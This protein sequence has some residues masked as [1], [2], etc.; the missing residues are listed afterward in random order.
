MFSLFLCMTL[1]ACAGGQTV[2]YVASTPPHPCIRAFLD[3][4]ATDSIDF[5][6]WK[7]V[8]DKDNYQLEC[9]YGIGKPN[10]NGFINNGKNVAL[11]GVFA[12]QGE[13][14]TLYNK[15]KRI[16]MLAL[17]GNLVHLQDEHQNLLVGNSGW[18]FTLNRENPVDDSEAKITVKQTHLPDSMVFYGR[19]PCNGFREIKSLGISPSCY[20][21]K[22]EV[23]LFRD[24]VSGRPSVFRSRGTLFR[25]NGGQTGTW[26]IVTNGSGANV[27]RLALHNKEFLDLLP[28]D[29]NLLVF[30]NSDGQLL[31]GDEDFSY[32][33]NREQ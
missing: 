25:K 11:K 27:Y 32:T 24:P 26:E 1:F 9:N 5:I 21:L 28:I 19:T 8:F 30:L 29:E 6:R 15:N 3:I 23:V 22:W 33:L 12:K 31:T 2:T 10:T 7:L 16:Q 14:Y 20:K 4:P 17:N 18:S 13:Q